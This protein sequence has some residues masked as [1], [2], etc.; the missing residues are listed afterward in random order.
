MTPHIYIDKDGIVKLAEVPAELPSNYVP[1]PTESHELTGNFFIEKS[2]EATKSKAISE[3]TPFEDQEGV[4]NML[5][6]ASWTL[7]KETGYDEFVPGTYPLPPDFPKWKKVRQM[8]VC[9]G[10]WFDIPELQ[11][12]SS[13]VEYRTVIRFVDE[14]KEEVGGYP[15][16]HTGSYFLCSKCAGTGKN[17]KMSTTVSASHPDCPSCH[18][19]GWVTKS[20]Y[21]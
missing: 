13:R 2:L 11:F 7:N 5:P 15:L 10:D 8:S 18:G 17:P 14:K 21:E 1:C 9:D 6:T 3:A 16:D 19:R 12:D 4:G 20:N